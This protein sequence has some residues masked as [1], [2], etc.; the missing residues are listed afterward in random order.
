MPRKQKDIKSLC[1]SH[2][3]G[4]VKTL[5]G[6]MNQPKAPAASRVAAANTI[7][8]RGWGKAPQ[9]QTGEEGEGPVVIKVVTGIARD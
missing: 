3:E 6:I 1:R 9:P 7:L 4:A 2:T 8:D 5:I